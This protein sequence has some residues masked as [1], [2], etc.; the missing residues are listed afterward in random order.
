MRSHDSSNDVSNH[1]SYYSKCIEAIDFIA[2]HELNFALGNVVLI[3]HAVHHQ[4]A[5]TI[6]TYNVIANYFGWPR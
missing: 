5:T 4:E 2:S 3:S 1:P 6:P